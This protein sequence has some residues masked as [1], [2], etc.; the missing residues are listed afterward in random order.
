VSGPSTA[1]SANAAKMA[2]VRQA[3]QIGEV[4]AGITGPKQG[5]LGPL[6]GRM[7]FPDE[8]TAVLLK[9]AKNVKSQGLTSQIKDYIAIAQ[10]E[11][12]PFELWV[13]T[14]NRTKISGPLQAA[15][16]AGLVRIVRGIQ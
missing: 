12:V 15:E 4:A 11:G 8:H 1:L 14:G 13:R 10:N 5:V 2:G 7:R 9:E 6:S 3:G 16:Q